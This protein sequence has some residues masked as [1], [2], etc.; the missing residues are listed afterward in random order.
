RQ[1]PSPVAL[2][3]PPAPA[4]WL[5]R[6]L[7]HVAREPGRSPPGVALRAARDLR[8]GGAGERGAA[9][10]DPGVRRRRAPAGRTAR[11][12]PL[13][14]AERAFIDRSRAEPGRVFQLAREGRRDLLVRGGNRI[15]F[16]ADKVVSDR[17]RRV[18]VEPLTNVWDDVPFQGIAREG[19]ARFIRN[20]KP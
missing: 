19:G 9:R 4:G 13:A 1:G 14:A 5:R 3:R 6:G 15:L 7:R 17:G 11:A 12:A 16:L 2:Q 18:L 20:K 10:E 8:A